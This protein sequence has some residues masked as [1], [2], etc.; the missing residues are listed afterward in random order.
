[1]TI[2]SYQLDKIPKRKLEKRDKDKWD[3]SNWR[4]T[5]LINVDVKIGSEAIAKRLEN[6]LLNIIHYKY[7]TL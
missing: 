1:M 4:L 5:S 7:H 3:L 6:V 2:T